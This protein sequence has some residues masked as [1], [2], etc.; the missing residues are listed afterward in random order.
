MRFSGKIGIDRGTEETAPG[1]YEKQF[2]EIEVIGTVRRN[3]N[4]RWPNMNSQEVK[5]GNILSIIPPEKSSV[6]I[7]EVVYVWW[8]DRRWSVVDIE[9]IHPRVILSLGGLYNG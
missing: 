1:V 3:N 8:Q 7:N 5:I 2:D 6:D 4:A 9:Y